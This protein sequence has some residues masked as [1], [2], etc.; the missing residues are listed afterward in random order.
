M[1]PTLD[2]SY[3]PCSEGYSR[4]TT[5]YRNQNSPVDPGSSGTGPQWIRN[6]VDM[7][8]ECPAWRAI[9]HLPMRQLGSRMASSCI[10][11]SRS[12]TPSS[13][14]SFP[15]HQSRGTAWH[16]A[17]YFR[18]V[19]SPRD[20]ICGGGI[21]PCLPTMTPASPPASS[22][23]A[24]RPCSTSASPQQSR[25]SRSASQSTSP[26]TYL[27]RLSRS[28]APSPAVAASSSSAEFV[29]LDEAPVRG[30]Y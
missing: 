24:E 11:R 9:A 17:A 13:S 21:Q 4:V 5:R 1:K 7:I 10:W 15:S 22:K 14:S 23:P 6:T 20:V 2:K 28:L 8:A 3:S 16:D 18:H 26:G 19:P 29:N 27:T 30:F 25:H 12:K